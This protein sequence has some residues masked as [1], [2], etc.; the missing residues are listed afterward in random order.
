VQKAWGKG[1]PGIIFIDQMNK[2]NPTPKVG[3]YETTNPCV[4]GDTFVT[5][6][7]GPRQVKDLIGKRTTLVVNGK[8]LQ[9]RKKAF[10]QPALNRSF[11]LSL[12]RVI[13]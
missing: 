10:S 9:L 7:E 2:F 1:D 13:V 12:K 11:P 3:I 4:A 6:S 8:D 5:T